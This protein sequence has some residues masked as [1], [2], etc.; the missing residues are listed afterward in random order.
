[1]ITKLCNNENRTNMIVN[2]IQYELKKNYDQQI[3]I[4]AHNKNLIQIL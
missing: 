3:M 1:M 4:L 2:I